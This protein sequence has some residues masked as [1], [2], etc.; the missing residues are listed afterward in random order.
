M[1]RR[2]TATPASVS[3]IFAPRQ[4]I[5]DL[6]F[7]IFQFPISRFG[8]RGRSRQARLGWQNIA[9]GYRLHRTLP[10]TVPPAPG[11]FR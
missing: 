2:L 9:L 1:S 6:G 7:S 11:P 8:A 10:A 5:L 4:A 3:E